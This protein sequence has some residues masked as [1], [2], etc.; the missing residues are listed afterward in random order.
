MNHQSCHA[1]HQHRVTA[2]FGDH[3]QSFDLKP[4]T[5]LVQL[6]ERLA[7][8]A[9]QNHG[10][11]MGVTVLFDTAVEQADDA[12][13]RPIPRPIP[14]PIRRVTRAGQER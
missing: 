3:K 9:R 13:H 1:P 11:P 10:W 12:H 5:T 8:L 2:L 14:R 7:E 6:T 4:G